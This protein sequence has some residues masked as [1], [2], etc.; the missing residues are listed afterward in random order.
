MPRNREVA[1]DKQ[2]QVKIGVVKRLAKEA[3]YY[4]KETNEN[5]AKLAK[6]KEEGKDFYDIKKFNEV[7]DES[8]MMIPDSE[9]RLKRNVEELDILVKAHPDADIEI[10]ALAKETL[11]AHS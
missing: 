9:A 8:K 4:V 11:A 3:A 7:L 6:M 2:L 1:P 10:V 5:E